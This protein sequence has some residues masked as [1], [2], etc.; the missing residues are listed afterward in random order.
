MYQETL[1]Q[2]TPTPSLPTTR[3]QTQTIAT[4]YIP[5]IDLIPIHT[6]FLHHLQQKAVVKQKHEQSN[7]RRAM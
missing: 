2:A 4:E 5:S 1:A 7:L 3:A 6:H